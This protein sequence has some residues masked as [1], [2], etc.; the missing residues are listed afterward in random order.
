MVSVLCAQPGTEAAAGAGKT[1]VSDP[2]A[3]EK[4]ASAAEAERVKKLEA[5]KKAKKPD[6]FGF[7]ITFNEEI[8]TRSDVLRS[9][10]ARESDLGSPAVLRAERD[11]LLRDKVVQLVAAS[12]GITVIKDELDARIQALKDNYGGDAKYFEW[13]AQQGY[14]QARFRE[15]QRQLIL[16]AKLD[17]MLIAGISPDGRTLLPWAIRPSPRELRL[18]FEN[19]PIRKEAGVAASWVE[20]SI[21]L[22]NDEKR[23]LMLLMME[24]DVTPEDIREKTEEVLQPR[25]DALLARIASEGFPAVAKTIPTAKTGDEELPEKKSDDPAMRFLQEGPVRT[26]S[27]PIPVKAGWRFL[28]VVDRIDASQLRLEDEAVAAVYV[29]RIQQLRSRKWEQIL[30][31]RA[32]DDST[33]RPPRVKAEVRKSMLADLKEAVEALRALGIH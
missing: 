21:E 31:L 3:G 26:M 1:S 14:T 5:E 32:L 13:V 15:T 11:K 22:T 25:L 33:L 20:F 9:L 17:R 12:L 7:P 19:D 4:D 6:P 18:A 10:G 16:R 28:F 23:P 29:K 30:Q 24:D 2:T 27:P 8:I